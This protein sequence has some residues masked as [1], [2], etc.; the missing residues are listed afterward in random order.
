MDARHDAGDWTI[1]IE[2]PGDEGNW[3]NDGGEPDDDELH[4]MFQEAQDLSK[5]RLSLC[6]W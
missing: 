6:C 1:G 4:P 2:D 5:V 3:Q